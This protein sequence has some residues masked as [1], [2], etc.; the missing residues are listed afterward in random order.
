LLRV[1]PLWNK[2]GMSVISHCLASNSLD[3]LN[4][5]H[6]VHSVQIASDL[7]KTAIFLNIT[8]VITVNKYIF[9]IFITII[10]SLSIWTLRMRDSFLCGDISVPR[11]TKFLWIAIMWKYRRTQHSHKVCRVYKFLI[12]PT[13]CNNKKG[14][15]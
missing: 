15:N 6:T 7:Q 12:V 13:W 9:I 4:Y 11:L 5:V 3:H 2:D 14:L 1:I 10:H 8:I